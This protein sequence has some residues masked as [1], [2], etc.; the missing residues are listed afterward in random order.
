MSTTATSET[1]CQYSTKKAAGQKRKQEVEE[2]SAGADWKTTIDWT[3]KRVQLSSRRGRCA[4][5]ALS[6]NSETN[7]MVHDGHFT[8]IQSNS[9]TSSIIKIQL[10]QTKLLK[11]PLCD[12]QLTTAWCHTPTSSSTVTSG[13]H[14]AMDKSHPSN[15][16]FRLAAHLQDQVLLNIS[17]QQPLLL[18]VTTC[19]QYVWNTKNRKRIKYSKRGHSNS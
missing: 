3:Q 6:S 8:E 17:P 9:V 16:D 13:R 14:L 1:D 12:L 4:C 10:W 7:R 19:Q 18:L 2:L 11:V 15:S 5:R